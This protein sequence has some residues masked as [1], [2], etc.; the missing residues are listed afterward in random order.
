MFQS[1]FFYTVKLG[2]FSGDCLSL[3]ITK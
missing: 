1:T 2:T 3:R